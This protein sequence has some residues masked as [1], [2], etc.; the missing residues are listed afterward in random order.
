MS[1]EHK[2]TP[3]TSP[4]VRRCAYLATKTDYYRDPDEKLPFDPGAGNTA[5]Y[6]CMHTQ[7]S[8][9]PDEDHCHLQDCTPNRRCYVATKNPKELIDDAEFDKGI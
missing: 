6:W 8:L 5:V 3:T 9:G 1:A 2:T 7:T 4:N